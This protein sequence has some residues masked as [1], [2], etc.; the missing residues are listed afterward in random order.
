MWQGMVCR[1]GG[2]VDV[3][4]EQE[5]TAAEQL[6]EAVSVIDAFYSSLAGRLSLT[7]SFGRC[8]EI[9]RVL[10]VSDVFNN[11]R[12]LSQTMSSTHTQLG[13][14]TL[15]SR[16][17]NEHRDIPCLSSSLQRTKKRSQALSS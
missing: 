15:L 7:L 9:D 3:Q 17:E 5:S 2:L 12:T 14:Q 16:A 11:A 1:V 13:K 6:E 10:V 4:V 8:D